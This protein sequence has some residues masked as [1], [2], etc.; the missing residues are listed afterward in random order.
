MGDKDKAA[1]LW[2][3]IMLAAW[4]LLHLVNTADA[5]Y[6]APNPQLALG[7]IRFKY[8]RQWFRI[9]TIQHVA[10]FFAKLLP[11]W[12]AEPSADLPQA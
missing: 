5:I 9:D 4:S 1:E 12:P 10:S 11:Y 2:Q 7:G 6:F 3:A 8:T